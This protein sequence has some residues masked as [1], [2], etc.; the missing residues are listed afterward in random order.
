MHV[1]SGSCL[2]NI[3]IPLK[4]IS[5]R[6]VVPSVRGKYVQVVP[7]CFFLLKFTFHR[8]CDKVLH[9]QKLRSPLLIIRSYHTFHLV[10][11]ITQSPSKG[12]FLHRIG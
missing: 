11:P 4:T 1:C 9:M 10:T 8:L 12:C 2:D 6:D 3:M 7:E 5:G